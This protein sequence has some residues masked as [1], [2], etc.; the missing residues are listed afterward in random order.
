MPLLI[1][2]LGIGLLLLL[3]IGL[4][5]N[6]FLALIIVAFLIGFA[7]GM[8]VD[9]VVKSIE[10]GVG[11]TLGSLALILGFGSMLGSLVAESGAAQQITYTLIRSF[12]EKHIQWAMV[13]T[14]F[15]VGIPLFYNAGFVLLIPIVFA[16]VAA[17]RLPSLYIGIPM[18]AALSV[19]HGYLPPHPGPSAIAVSYHAD[20]GL[21][22]VYG[23]CVAIPAIIVAGPMLG[24]YLKRKPVAPLKDLFNFKQRPK[25]EMPGF[26][27]SLFTALVPVVLMAL[28]AL[29][30]L[31]LPEDSKAR[32]FFNLVG[33][34]VIALLI[35]VLIAIITLGLQRGK[36]MSEI[37]QILSDS[38]GGIAM[39]L[40]TIAGGGALKQVLVD[41]GVGKYIETIVSDSSFSPLFLA[42]SVAAILRVCLGSATVAAVSTAG[43]VLP[44]IAST[45][46]SPELMVL[47]TGAGSLMFSHVNDPGFWM[48]KEYFNLTIGQTL[49]SWS[50]METIVSVFGLIGVLLLEMII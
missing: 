50:V 22:L 7:E 27:A 29:G 15:V 33:N 1:A 41:S 17:T 37:M 38:I 45:S 40:L 11:S 43:I 9:A 44:L 32:I 28:S 24:I 36:K 30:G 20:M 6:A 23:L 21:T 19:T 46:V 13:L 34:P 39:I 16:I 4:K 2:A 26:A 12:G 3:M 49:S 5:F 48:F 42:W 10:N 8:P 35:A 14:G 31:F 47:A 18:A 25:S